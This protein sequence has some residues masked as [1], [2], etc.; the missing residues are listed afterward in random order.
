MY[1]LKMYREIIFNPV[2]YWLTRSPFNEVFRSFIT[3][4][5]PP[6]IKFN[7]LAYMFT[8]YAFA[9][10]WPLAILNYVLIGVY[11]TFDGSKM[12]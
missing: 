7:I 4:G 5:I 2:K 8:Y 3:S 12:R 9:V 11:G 10:I 6:H 1:Q